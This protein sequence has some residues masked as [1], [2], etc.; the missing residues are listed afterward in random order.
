MRGCLAL[1]ADDR[2]IAVLLA[3]NTLDVS[4]GWLFANR[5]ILT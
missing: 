5:G 4:L 3:I 2:V 1:D